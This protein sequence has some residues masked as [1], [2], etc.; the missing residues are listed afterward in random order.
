MFYYDMFSVFLLI[1]HIIMLVNTGTRG[2]GSKS[3]DNICRHSRCE[4]PSSGL[5]LDRR[6]AGTVDFIGCCGI[7]RTSRS[8][9]NLS[10]Q[11]DYHQVIDGFQFQDLRDALFSPLHTISTCLIR[12]QK[13]GRPYIHAIFE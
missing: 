6:Y 3:Y 7:W 1:Y 5:E 12:I 11:V 9:I 2:L 4:I 10:I 13:Q 8:K